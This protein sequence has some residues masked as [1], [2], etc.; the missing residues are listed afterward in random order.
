[1]RC[2]RCEG[3]ELGLLTNNATKTRLCCDLFL[4]IFVIVAGDSHIVVFRKHDIFKVEVAK[5]KAL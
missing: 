1:M 2:A 4:Q 5:R 3:E